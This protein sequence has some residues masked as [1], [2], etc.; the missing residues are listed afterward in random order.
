MLST[1]H[2]VRSVGKASLQQSSLVLSG[3]DVPAA[4]LSS[5]GEGRELYHAPPIREPGYS[6]APR[7]ALW[8]NNLYPEILRPPPS[9]HPT[10]APLTHTFSPIF[11]IFGIFTFFILL[12][13]FS[14]AI[15]LLL[16]YSSM[17]F[18]SSL[19]RLW[20]PPP[21]LS[22]EASKNK[23]SLCL[24]TALLLCKTAPDTWR[25]LKVHV[26]NCCY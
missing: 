11:L 18:S 13:L 25:S 14:L 3:S 4:P 9:P 7:L 12:F 15:V 10:P 5:G 20:P 8:M 26:P 16:S 24:P 22:T 2:L 17:L 6:N 19:H 1:L 21:N 23:L